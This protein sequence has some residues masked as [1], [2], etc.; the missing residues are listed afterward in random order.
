MTSHQRIAIGLLVVAGVVIAFWLATGRTFFRESPKEKIYIAVEGEG[1]VD[2]VDPKTAKVI[3]TIDLA[4][5]HDGGILRFAPH[6]I[7]ASPDSVSVWVTANAGEHE[8]H[9]ASLVPRAL[10]HGAEDESAEPDEIIIIDPSTDRIVKRIGIAPGA[11]LAHV[12][13]SPDGATAYVTAQTR[14]TI[15]RVNT[16]TYA[17]EARIASPAE[18][19]PHG[20]RMSP[21]GKHAYVA[22][23]AGK[24]LGILDVAKNSL[25]AIP[26]GGQAI[27]TG[28]TPDGRFVAVSL[29]DTRSVAIYG[30]ADGS[31]RTVKLPASSRGPIQMYPTPDSKYFYLADQGP[32][33]GQPTGNRVY[34]ID[35]AAGAVVGETVAGD[36]PHGVVVSPDGATVFVTNLRSG[37]VSIIETAT[38]RERIRIPV[39]NKPNGITYWSQERVQP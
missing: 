32:S 25:A 36:G 39:G 38:D 18:S 27:Q 15:Y 21:D 35:V 31:V 19:E 12:V 37:D 10:A 29:Y 5:S 23:L 11:H 13:F 8:D 14:G 7:Q 16:G 33:L 24:A 4:I 20:I 6:N 17:I 34:K 28:V 22:L 2:V 30:T 26:L 1:V 3:R 9:A